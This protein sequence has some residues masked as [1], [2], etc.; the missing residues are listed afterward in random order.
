MVANPSEHVRHLYL[1]DC[2]VCQQST[3][4]ERSDPEST[5]DDDRN[6]E[7]PQSGASL[8]HHPAGSQLLHW[9]C[10]REWDR[11][12]RCK[13]KS[14][15]GLLENDIKGLQS[16]ADGELTVGRCIFT[17]LMATMACKLYIVYILTY[18]L[19]CIVSSRIV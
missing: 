11:K 3:A 17:R 5:N 8:Y 14:L 4:I 7:N 9:W 18:P 2:P 13:A 19:N 1:Y 10:E 12:W 16:A 6:G 15:S